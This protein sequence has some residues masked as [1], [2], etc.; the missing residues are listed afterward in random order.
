MV[1]REEMT[2]NWQKEK[3]EWY[4]EAPVE[5]KNFIH[6]GKM[7]LYQ[8]IVVPTLLYGYEE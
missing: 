3:G 4:T 8:S 1:L 2:Q 5:T 6:G 7:R